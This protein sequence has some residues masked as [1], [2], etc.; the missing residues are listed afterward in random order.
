MDARGVTVLE[1]VVV[2]ALI[3]VATGFGA[4][5]AVEWLPD[6][7]LDAAARQVVMDLRLARARAM[8]EQERRRLL[9]AAGAG[10]YLRQ[11][12]AGSSWSDDGP[13][14]SLPD[15]IRAVACTAPGG[16]FTF[17]PRGTAA[18]F[19]TLALRNVRGRERRIV[20]DIVG[21]VRVL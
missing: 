10:V 19:G 6:L 2:A 7:R 13:P 8:A 15:G 1:V 21:R 5:R 12:A 17:A 3:G 4:W 9:V 16:A 11:R 20:V 14:V 18:T